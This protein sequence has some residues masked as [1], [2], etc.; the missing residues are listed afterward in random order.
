MSRHAVLILGMHR[1]RTSLLAGLLGGGG[2]AVPE[3]A[4]PPTADNPRG[5]WESRAIARL[6]NHLLESAGTRWNDDAPIDSGWFA[7][8]AREADREEALALLEASFG[9]TE[10][11]VLKDPRL[12]RLLPFWLSVLSKA[13][14]EC[15]VVLVLRDP[16][17]VARSLAARKD[18]PE[19]RPAAV[20]ATSR[21]LLLWLRYVLDAERHSRGLRRV[22][23]DAG[24]L[25][26]EWQVVLRR[27]EVITGTRF[28]ESGMTLQDGLA[29]LVDA[30]L[31]RQRSTEDS[32]GP[33]IAQGV[34]RLRS[35]CR[36]LVAAGGQP[37]DRVSRSCD[38]LAA[39]LDR[40][41]RLYAPLR[42]DAD[43]L[44]QKDIWA[45]SMLGQLSLVGAPPARPR[46]QPRR[47]LFLSGSPDSVG[48]IYRVEHPV[49]ALG[50]RGWVASWLPLEHCEAKDRIA[51]ADTVVIFRVQGGPAF[52]VVRAQCRRLG[53]PLVYDIDD[54]VFEPEVMLAGHFAYL[55]DLTE[56]DRFRWIEDA[57]RYREALA[58]CDAATVTTTP[59]ATAASRHCKR[60]AVLPNC[61]SP[62]L[63]RRAD[64]ALAVVKPSATDGRL[65][66]GFASGTPTHRR[67]FAV[68]A[69]ALGQ[70]FDQRPEPLLVVLG[71]CDLSAYPTLARHGARI[72]LRPRVPME[73]LFAEVARFDVN[74]APLE[75]ANPF[76]EAKSAVRCNVAAMLGVPTIASS[77]APL[78]TAIVHGSTG[79]LA[80]SARAWFDASQL[81]TDDAV[82]SRMSVAA[83][84][85][86]RATFGAEFYSGLA[87]RI[88]AAIAD[89]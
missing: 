39:T 21:A 65:R 45:Q 17:E 51:D 3:D 42:R 61:L 49:H 4:M 41:V 63:A 15:S 76:C 26:S 13:D 1:S 46:G 35:L 75:S 9:S 48:H 56:Q 72:E 19:F 66:L 27:L 44:D 88:F 36:M 71:D 54:L 5:Y 59:L 79:L 77:T 31:Y 10:R 89:A 14:V 85:Q 23:I 64:A 18:V 22:S 2:W 40:L 29:G 47:V 58:A 8:K 38:A 57:A 7:D 67:D 69:S 83:K 12:C 60:V 82:R 52:E 87:E 11:F 70:L 81:L 20:V 37:L 43:L 78:R 25:V 74:L 33:D 32:G 24:Q 73:D 6:N 34:T 68:A 80:S 28:A 62:S 55:D 30:D 84:I 53:V 16:L 86:A 50:E